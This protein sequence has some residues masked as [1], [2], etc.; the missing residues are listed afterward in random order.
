M[1]WFG[2]LVFSRKGGLKWFWHHKIQENINRGVVVV[3]FILLHKSTFSKQAKAKLYLYFYNKYATQMLFLTCTLHT[4]SW[5]YHPMLNLY[6]GVAL[7]RCLSC[8]NKYVTPTEKLHIRKFVLCTLKLSNYNALFGEGAVLVVPIQPK[9]TD[10]FY[11]L[12]LTLGY[13]TL[14]KFMLPL[15]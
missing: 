14:C 9:A 1:H 2:N 4:E 5:H 15:L 13:H 12:Q 10:S 3:G 7:M 8:Q 11:C 6:V